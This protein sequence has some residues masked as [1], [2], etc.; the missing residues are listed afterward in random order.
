MDGSHVLALDAM[1]G[2]NAPDVVVAGANVA[3]VRYPHLHFRLFGNA[4][5]LEKLMRRF[6]KARP[7]R[8]RHCQ[9]NG[10]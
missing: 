4:E 9:R 8:H 1:G 2:D 10:N 7:G 3:R 6:P 5:K